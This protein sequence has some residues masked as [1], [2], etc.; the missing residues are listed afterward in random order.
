MVIVGH[1][2]AGM[3]GRFV[4]FVAVVAVLWTILR[5]VLAVVW[6]GVS[7]RV[8]ERHEHTRR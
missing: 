3:I 1:L 8:A 2:V 6:R 7:L 5:F 4:I